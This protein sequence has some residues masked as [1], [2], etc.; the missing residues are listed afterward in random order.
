MLFTFGLNLFAMDVKNSTGYYNGSVYKAFHDAYNLMLM[1]DLT[2]SFDTFEEQVLYYIG[3]M[4]F[5]VVM[6]NLLISVI[7]DVYAVI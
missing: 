1:A 5:L 4:F 3:T 6:M 7:T 2:M